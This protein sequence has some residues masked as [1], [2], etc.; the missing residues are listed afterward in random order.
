M[1]KFVFIL[2]IA[3]IA[4]CS[5][6][7]SLK[8]KAAFYATQ[9]YG[10]PGTLLEYSVDTVTIG[11]NLNYRIQSAF[12]AADFA[13]SILSFEEAS[14]KELKSFGGSPD[15]ASLEKSRRRVEMANGKL[16]ALDSLKEA[17]APEVLNQVAALTFILVY[18]NPGSIVYVQM[19]PEGNLIAVANNS[20]DCLINPGED[21]PGY[22]EINERFKEDFSK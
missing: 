15:M 21:A 17:L 13:E 2:A 20:D 8:S 11:D 9:A 12:K 19:D 4:A 1:K 14:A 3:S 10:T 7:N 18:N 22:L 16:A 5:M 6:D